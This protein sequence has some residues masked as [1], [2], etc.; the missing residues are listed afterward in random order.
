MKDFKDISKILTKYTEE[1]SDSIKEEAIELGNI[2]AD[3][4]KRTSP[5]RT[6]KYGKGWKT[7]VKSGNNFIN[8]TIH[9]KNYQLTHLLEKG[10]ATRNGG[11]TK[12][13]PHIAPVESEVNQMFVRNV[14]KIIKNG[15]KR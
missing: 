4:L 6:G 13:Q 8:V 11:R 9:N 5:K 1:V 2:G 7:T 3:K 15:G 14:E 12:A 10:H